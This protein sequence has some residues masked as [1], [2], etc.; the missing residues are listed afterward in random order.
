MRARTAPT[1]NTLTTADATPNAVAA[2]AT[3]QPV[4]PA[5]TSS[6]NHAGMCGPP[7]WHST[8]GSGEHVGDRGAAGDRQR[9]VQLVADLRLRVQPE[10]REHRGRQVFRPGLPERRVR[11][12]PV[13]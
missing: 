10:R 8:P 6:V 11:P 3:S 7:G 4:H 9:A 5:G 13:A 2:T 1:A 12:E